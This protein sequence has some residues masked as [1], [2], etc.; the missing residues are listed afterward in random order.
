MG[1]ELLSI[2]LDL[3]RSL[4]TEDRYRRL[5]ETVEALVPCDAACLLRVDGDAFVPVAARGLSADTL[6]RRF[7]R[8]Q[9]PRLDI[10]AASPT[11]VRFPP[12]AS[13]PDPFDGMLEID[14]T[15]LA[16]VHACLGCPLTVEGRL[17]GVLT[18]DSLAPDAFEALDLDVLSWL[19]ALAGA[20]MQT[21]QLI[22]SLEASAQQL[23][24]VNQDLMRSAAEERGTLL[25]TSV[26]MQAL[27]R[28]IDLVAAAEMTVL[29]TGETG[30][31]KELVARAL[32]R[33]S[34]RRN[35][36]LIHVNCAALP[37]SV[38]ESELFGHVRGAFTGA[39][40]NR[41]GKLEVADGGTLLLDEVGE[42]PPS[43]QPKL[44]RA[45]Q[46]GE[47]QRVGSDQ[48]FRVD[49]RVIAAT[50]RKLEEEVAA[51]R[52][53]ED[54]FHRLNVYRVHVPPLRERS[55]D[56]ALLAG[57]FSDQA[58]LRV[59]CGP[60]R[61]APEA[62]ERLASYEWPGNVR[63]LENLV[64]RAV[65]RAA[66]GARRDARVVVRA[67]HLLDGVHPSVVLAPP[68]TTPSAPSGGTLAE[69]V[70]AFRRALI[71]RTVAAHGGNWAAAARELGL[72]RSN[73]HH[74]AKR[75]GLR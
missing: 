29:I 43:V 71:A 6:G 12:D 1:P 54:L 37:E 64:Q 66:A 36:P 23:G 62:L 44:L 74:L 60:V 34:V 18:A 38:A 57:H 45:L 3:T 13:L 75:L 9:H 46:E 35:R 51:G 61:L 55:D 17:V 32:H 8:G 41:A 14:P 58:R 39:E 68:M 47:I 73:L 15:A 50:N 4:G 25:G 42:L 5:L 21:S 30:T 67:E 70:D 16:D 59:G 48:V 10:I 20:A 7:A 56:V 65:L 31:G 69:Q 28:E 49:V 52:F 33:G 27:R 40:S 26:S 63:E 2:A 24:L 11:P 72:H 53:R 19:G 22:S